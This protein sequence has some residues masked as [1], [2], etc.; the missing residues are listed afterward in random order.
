MPVTQP[1]GELW[2]LVSLSMPSAWPE[3][4]EDTV[5]ELSASWRGQGTGFI[6]AG[7]FSLKEVEDRWVDDAGRAYHQRA[8]AHLSNTADAGNAM[9]ELG[10][11]ADVYAGEVAAVKLAIADTVARYEPLYAQVEPGLRGEFVNG[12]AAE[13][14]RL[15]REAATRVYEAGGAPLG[16]AEV[17]P[18]ETTPAN[19]RDWWQTLPTAT[20]DALKAENPDA[21][22]NLD[23]IPATVRDEL[24]REALK[25]ELIT[26]EVQLANLP[27]QDVQNLDKFTEVNGRVRGLRS[28]TDQL[29]QGD[30][31]LLG[32]D[33]TGDG[34]AIVALGNPDT[35]ANV[36]TVV[37][38]ANSRLATIGDDIGRA[39]NLRVAAGNAAADSTT[40][41]QT[42]VIAWVGYDAPN[43]ADANWDA[44]AVEAAPKL[45][46]F[47]D[48]L[49]A[50]HIGPDA[51]Q[52][53]IAHSYGTV[54]TGIAAHRYGL[55]VDDVALVASPGIPVDHVSHLRLDGVP[56]DQVGK[57]VYALTNGDRDWIDD[58]YVDWA[59]AYRTYPTDQEWGAVVLHDDSGTG[60]GHLGYLDAGTASVQ[61]LGG[62]II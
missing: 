29:A 44:A 60:D 30:K 45:D 10:R 15:L 24:N 59:N 21:I 3:A 12:V 47:E 16:R 5:R 17:P 22:R 61:R 23:G 62:I 7:G 31:F 38:G 50:T 55:D 1:T 41:G 51:H 35:A 13:V 48:G 46:R 37:P 6:E 40:Y 8:F 34:T 14:S 4:N 27:P 56:P 36:S 33:P 2:R 18:P 11:R 28:L 32:L 20:Q 19:I 57:H 26:A 52:T 49:R 58:W 54:V 43:T 9:V 39:E 25:R 42:S 53:I